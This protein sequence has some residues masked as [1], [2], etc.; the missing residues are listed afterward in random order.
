MEVFPYMSKRFALERFLGLTKK[1]STKTRKCGVKKTA[2]ILMLSQR[3][4]IYA[5]LV[6]SAGDIDSDLETADSIENAPPE[7]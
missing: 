3:V 5:I 1:K 6:F 4:M 7:M 2:K